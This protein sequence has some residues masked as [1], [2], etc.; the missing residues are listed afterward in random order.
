MALGL[1][2]IPR[3][4]A[5]P[6]TEPSAPAVSMRG[7]LIADGRYA[8]NL[9]DQ[10]DAAGRVRASVGRQGL[11]AWADLGPA[12]LA[13]PLGPGH[14]VT[15]CGPGGCLETVSTDAGPNRAMLKTGRI[16]DLAPGLWEVVCGLPR[17]RGL[18]EGTWTVVE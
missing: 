18:C 7:T 10:S 3:G 4:S 12:Y 1:V 14:R 2:P 13:I 15:I 11:I 6:V 5:L 17:S 16:A 8:T 9:R